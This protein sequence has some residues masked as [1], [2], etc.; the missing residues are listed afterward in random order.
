MA[1]LTLTNLHPNEYI[2][3]LLYYYPFSVNL[4]R[5]MGSCN[6]LNDLS[7]KVCVPNR[8]EDLT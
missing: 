6:S 4:D 1:Q 7:N 2:K 5:C 8:I 3:G